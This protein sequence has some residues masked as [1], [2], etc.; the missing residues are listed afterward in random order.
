MTFKFLPCHTPSWINVPSFMPWRILLLKYHM[1]L[2][3]LFFCPGAYCQ[4][5]KKGKTSPVIMLLVNQDHG[6]KNPR[7]DNFCHLA[8]THPA[9]TLHSPK[10]LSSRFPCPH[11]RYSLPRRVSLPSAAPLTLAWAGNKC[12]AAQGLGRKQGGQSEAL[13]GAPPCCSD[14]RS[15]ETRSIFVMPRSPEISSFCASGGLRDVVRF[16]QGTTMSHFQ[17]HIQEEC[18]ASI[19]G[20]AHHKTPIRPLLHSK[21]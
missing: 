9:M 19:W 10:Q 7:T 14:L 8:S 4:Y 20:G 15:L 3:F 1:I 6:K 21:D 5:I 17:D 11:G 16:N 18:C 12:F 13:S 2:M